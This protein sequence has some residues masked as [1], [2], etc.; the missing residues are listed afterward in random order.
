MRKENMIEPQN[1][2]CVQAVVSGSAFLDNVKSSVEFLQFIKEN[3]IS[4]KKLKQVV[5]GRRVI[6]VIGF[7]KNYGQEYFDVLIKN[8]IQWSNIKSVINKLNN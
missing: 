6:E 2:Q 5:F 1:P 3:K 8:N 7:C 4:Y